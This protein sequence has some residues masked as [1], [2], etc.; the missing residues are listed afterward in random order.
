M[1]HPA[2]A[3]AIQ[4]SYTYGEPV[5]VDTP[6]PPSLLPSFI[7]SSLWARPCLTIESNPDFSS[8]DTLNLLEY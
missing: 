3:K 8:A 6:L 7:K 2:E 5:S 1:G 4:A